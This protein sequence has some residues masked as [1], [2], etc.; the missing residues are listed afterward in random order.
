MAKETVQAVRKAETSAEKLLKD[1][2]VKKDEIISE[3]M[4]KAKELSTSML[5]EAQKNAE[6]DV[7]EAVRRS[8]QI[9]EEAKKEAEKEVE[10]LIAM[11]KAK[12][13]GAINLV[14]SN[15]V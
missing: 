11:A 12:Q 7:K 10:L 15:V 5:N 1:A 14:I 6:N 9:L 8:N 4:Q 3:A 2:Q 13:Q